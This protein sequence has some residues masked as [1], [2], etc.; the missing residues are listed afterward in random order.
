[1][2]AAMRL[3]LTHGAYLL[4][5]ALFILGLKQL[6]RV[7]TAR[8]GNT[9]AAS[10]MLI[11]I[12]ATLLTARDINPT[13]IAAGLVVGSG[14]GLAMAHWV[15]M[16]R[17]PELVALFN[18][19]GG[20]A[21]AAVAWAFMAQA[22]L[23][24]D[25][26][27]ATTLGH[28]TVVV[29]FL[30]LTIGTLTLTGSLV[31]FG[32]LSGVLPGRSLLL[33]AR[34]VLNLLLAVGLIGTAVAASYFA[35]GALALHRFAV[36]VLIAAALG[37]LLVVPIGGADMPVVISLL[38]SYSGL[39]ASMA[40]FVLLSQSKPS[41]YLL[42]IAGA[43]VGAA[44][45]IL[46]NLMCRAMNRSLINVLVGGFGETSS[47]QAGAEEYGTVTSTSAEEAALVLEAAQRVI[48]VP[49][50]G[51]AV[52]QA[53][54]ALAEVAQHLIARGVSVS[55]AIH[56]VAG[57]M[58][59]HMNVLLAE[60]K[61]PYELLFDLDQINSEFAQTDVAIVVGANDVVNPAAIDEPD[62]PIYGMPVL[63]CHEAHSVI[64]IKRS[65]SPG[66]AGIKNPLFERD[67]A[68]LLFADAKAALTDTLKAL[69]ES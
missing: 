16:T 5:T 3:A 60:A 35:P 58:P 31:A 38:N 66:Y 44:G 48:L 19:L 59:G 43:L 39:A 22:P 20:A 68:M 15:A 7:R 13:W 2:S 41:A 49:G 54:H 65:L 9:L 21:S 27:L 10:G 42:I 57:R 52:A 26:H 4:A 47:G 34:H 69:R 30:S 12:V 25:A 63:N 28:H 36:V 23:S 61:V 11:A 50:Y 62:S 24:A 18:G 64:V 40:G 32:K 14:I 51:L 37:I 8:R 67:N 53:Q 6:S 55:Y 56:P 17:M 29:I 1:M 46:T 33:P 45:L